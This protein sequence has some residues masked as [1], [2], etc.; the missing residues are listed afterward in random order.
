MASKPKVLLLG[1]IDHA[2]ALEAYEALSSL[3]T[4][5]TTSAT[6]PKDFLAECRNGALDGVKVIYRTFQSVSLTGR[7][8]GEIVDALS[9][10]GVKAICHN[11]AGYD[12][13]DVQAC[14]DAGIYVSHVPVAVDNATAD[15]A[16]FLLLGALRAFNSPL[17]ALRNGKWRGGSPPLGHDPEG[18]V[19]G[20]LGMGGIGKNLKKKAEALGMKV[21]YHNRRKLSSEDAGGAEYVSFEELLSGSDVISCNLPL[22]VS[23]SID[24][25]F[26]FT[27]SVVLSAMAFMLI[28]VGA[29]EIDASHPFERAIQNDER[30]GS[31]CQYGT[32]SC[33]RRGCTGGSTG[34]WQSVQCRPGRV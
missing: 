7:I 23:I 16:L 20:I 28:F 22:N 19:L 12:Q 18:K 17:L 6:N 2:S 31:H 27:L 4:L 11:G 29:I 5:I 30:L 33:D 24:M 10:I 21:I 1:T 9:K 34:Q 15:T 32:G 13:I 25:L 26:G 8:A 3:A 14:T